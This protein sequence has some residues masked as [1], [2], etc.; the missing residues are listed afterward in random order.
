MGYLR[1]PIGALPSSVSNA[2]LRLYG[3]A[4]TSAK[5][6]SAYSVASTTWVESSINWNNAPASGSS[7][8]STVN[9]TLTA[10]YREW[11]VTAYVQAQKALEAQGLADPPPPATP[12]VPTIT[13]W[14]DL[15]ALLDTP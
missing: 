2:K 13:H 14:Q 8:L 11:D 15:L 3:A 5:A 1:F 10:Q 9:V 12:G 7:K 6:I 4:V